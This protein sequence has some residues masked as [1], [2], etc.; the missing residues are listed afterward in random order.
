MADDWDEKVVRVGC[1]RDCTRRSL[2]QLIPLYLRPHL[3]INDQEEREYNEM[4]KL[5]TAQSC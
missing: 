1:H 5:L 2:L 4:A 3:F